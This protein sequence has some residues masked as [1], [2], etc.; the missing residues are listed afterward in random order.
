MNVGVYFLTAFLLY[1]SL[2]NYKT[3]V[4][5]ISPSS[6][7]HLQKGNGGVYQTVDHYLHIFLE[8][9]FVSIYLLVS[10]QPNRN[11]YAKRSPH[12]YLF[13]KGLLIF[14]FFFLFHFILNIKNNFPLNI[15]FLIVTTFHLSEFLLSSLHNR[16]NYNYYNFLVNPNCGYVF[17]FI[18]TLIEYY[19]KIFFFILGHFCEKYFSRRLLQH[20]LLVNYFFF[21]KFAQNGRA[22]CTYRYATTTCKTYILNN[23]ICQKIIH[24][25]EGIFDK[26]EARGSYERADRYHLLLVLL[27]MVVCLCG[28]LL[29]V[30]G[31]LHCNR[32]FCFY[33][34]S[35]EHLADRC[36]R[37]KHLL[38]KS[39]VYKYMRHPCYTGWFYYALFLQLL[40][41]N[42]FC[43]VLCFFVSW[44]YFYRT[45]KMEE[46]YL[47][48]CYGE[49][50][51]SYKRETPHV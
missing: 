20:L 30:L 44:A 39:G 32:N 2:L 47:L 1:T 42:V 12:N 6:G 9:G 16:N 38:V 45:I 4:H 5:L 22:V 37:K 10:F 13:A 34:L 36:I 25:Y 49:E 35:T 15:F 19:S 21:K 51:R 3:L 33:V 46:T 24:Q 23:S 7:A 11:V 43:F 28:L 48:E 40:L 8:H 41:L 50:Y 29:R 26:Y 31:L 27:S 17:F 18:L 14:F